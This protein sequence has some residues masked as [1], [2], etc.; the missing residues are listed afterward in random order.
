VPT[1]Q[2]RADRQRDGGNVDRGCGHERGGRG[3]V[4]AGR[5]DH[6]VQWIAEQDFDQANIG[7]VSIEAGGGPLSRFLDR[8]N[9]KL[10]R[11]AASLDD[12]RAD[13]LGEDEV[14]TIARA[15]IAARLGDSH[16][17]LARLQLVQRQTEVHVAFEIEGGH[18]GIGR[19][20]EPCAGTKASRLGGLGMCHGACPNKV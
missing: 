12:A 5:Q 6:P 17:R 18:V 16:D 8:M 2:H 10:E 7:K 14:M 11:N 9:R 19:V 3:F 1:I 20:V 13:A 4:A 15:E